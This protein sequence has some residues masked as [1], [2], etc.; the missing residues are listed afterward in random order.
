M[1]FIL[2]PN[3]SRDLDAKGAL[4]NKHSEEI[5]KQVYNRSIAACHLGRGVNCRVYLQLDS[6]GSILR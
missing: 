5:K 3:S 2:S 4:P 6:A 1:S